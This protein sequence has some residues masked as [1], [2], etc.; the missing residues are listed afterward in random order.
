MDSLIIKPLGALLSTTVT[1][2]LLVSDLE[3]LAARWRKKAA[4]LPEPDTGAQRLAG[5]YLYYLNKLLA[6]V[7]GQR[8]ISKSELTVLLTQWLIED[9]WACYGEQH[10]PAHNNVYWQEKTPHLLPDTPYDL[11]F[12][13]PG[14]P[15]AGHCDFHH[16]SSRK[17]RSLFFAR[18]EPHNRRQAVLI[19]NLQIDEKRPGTWTRPEQGE[20]LTQR[21]TAELLLLQHALKS[22]VT[23]GYKKI[24]LQGGEMVHWTQFRRPG[25][26]R[27]LLTPENYARYQKVV[28]ARQTACEKIA[29]GDLLGHP[30]HI[31]LFAYQKT[32]R[33]WRAYQDDWNHC[34]DIYLRFFDSPNLKSEEVYLCEV[35]LF[36]KL[37]ARE[38]G[39][40]GGTLNE[41]LRAAGLTPGDRPALARYCEFFTQQLA[42]THE[43]SPA[44][45]PR[46][47]DK[48]FRKFNY[49]PELLRTRPFIEKIIAPRDRAMY[50]DTRRH[51]AFHEL[52]AGPTELSPIGEHY[53]DFTA[54][55]EQR[56][57][58]LYYNLDYRYSIYRWY[59]FQLPKLLNSLGLDYTQVSL[60]AIFAEREISCPAWQITAGLDKFADCAVNC[61]LII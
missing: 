47:L 7:D 21:R 5:R 24:L 60:P 12:Y 35:A 22:A 10:L 37:K 61:F 15:A 58:E 45:F 59:E 30:N 6:H 3:A 29:P 44:H 32:A 53:L 26:Q 42:Q 57:P 50:I 34:H 20:I 48:F 9:G 14:A 43:F 41:F 4:A 11:A 51:Q 25:P 2:Y 18:F 33:G 27:V 38:L 52:P 39:A 36:T 17:N 31:A 54:S 56:F 49:I 28:Q 13:H 1:D 46:W 55:P 16:E 8:K 40:L 19:G 23:A